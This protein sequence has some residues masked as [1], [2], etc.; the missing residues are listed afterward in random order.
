M[1]RLDVSRRLLLGLRFAALAGVLV[2]AVGLAGWFA[3]DTPLGGTWLTTTLGPTAYVVIAHP[4]SAMSRLR[5]GVIG[6]ATAIAVGLTTLAAFGLWNAPSVA[7]T[8]VERP[9]QVVAQAVA[10]GVTLLVLTLARAHHPPS[11][12]TALLIA[13]G[14]AAPGSPLLGLVV[15]LVIVLA[16]APLLAR[17]PGER[18]D[19]ADLAGSET[20][21][22]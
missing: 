10:L 9:A 15:G 2:A 5:N 20:P 17:L 14:I 13:S 7:E 6:H 8:H 16:A 22:G 4:R 21:M 3:R 11:G 1:I 12:A 18:D 19:T